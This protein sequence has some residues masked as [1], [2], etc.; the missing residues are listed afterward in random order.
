MKRTPLS[1]ADHHACIAC[2]HIAPLGQEPRHT[3]TMSIECHA[4]RWIPVDLT[5][6]GLRIAWNEFRS[7]I[8]ARYAD[9]PEC[10]KNVRVTDGGRI[11]SHLRQRRDDE[12]RRRAWVPCEGSSREMAEVA[13]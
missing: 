7:K 5:D 2:G 10:R 9:C 1:P 8:E 11:V 4:P 12:R 6:M 13:S 3:A